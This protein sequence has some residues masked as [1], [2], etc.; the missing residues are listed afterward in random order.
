MADK[1]STPTSSA[2]ERLI[3]GLLMRDPTLGP[4]F[5]TE[6]S[7]DDFTDPA[8]AFI[9][10]FV[11]NQTELGQAWTWGSLADGISQVTGRPAALEFPSSFISELLISTPEAVDVSL[12]MGFI[13]E[14]RVR[15]QVMDRAKAVMEIASNPLKTTVEL[16]TSVSQLVV[17]MK[18]AGVRQSIR[19]IGGDNLVDTFRREVL[20]IYKTPFIGTGFTTVDSLLTW[21]FAPGQISIITGRP[22]TGKSLFR[23]NVQRNLSRAGVGSLVISREQTLFAE[24]ARIIA[25]DQEI[26]LKFIPKVHEW[27][28]KEE[29]HHIGEKIM[30]TVEE[31]S[32][33]DIQVVDAIGQFFVIDIKRMILE[34]RTE[35]FNPQVVFVDLFAQLDDTNIVEN[36]AQVLQ[37]KVDETARI[38]RELGVHI[39][40][41]VQQRRGD[42]DPMEKLKGS[43]GFEERADLLFLIDRPAYRD[44][45]MQDNVM[46]VTI[47]KQRDGERNVVCKLGFTPKFI[48]LQDRST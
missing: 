6:M 25:I 11:K 21:G 36:Q 30:K 5:T 10:E 16:D 44:K 34:S 27:M 33:W 14:A 20:T 13:R 32:K 39:C 45:D 26:E 24:F 1:F 28:D 8:L 43:G 18:D 38:A 9:F 47:L 40:L 35:K 12:C 7:V 2:S 15:R 31:I 3:I 41:V 42:D 29:N 48:K 17:E 37:Q 4:K 19:R 22:S 23:S 46:E